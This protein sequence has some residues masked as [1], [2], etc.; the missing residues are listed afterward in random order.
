ME[1][2]AINK[3]NKSLLPYMLIAYSFFAFLSPLSCVFNICLIGLLIIS[4]IILDDSDILCFLAFASCFM[5]CLDIISRFLKILDLIMS[6]WLVKKLF[7]SIKFKNKKNITLIVAM[8][9]FFI[10]LLI[11]GLILFA[12]FKVIPVTLT[13][14]G[15]AGFILS[16]TR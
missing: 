15:I 10:I 8:L 7:Y 13:L 11:Y 4:V 1:T 14:A 2:I 3:L 16:V 12:L 9:A 5:A 6:V